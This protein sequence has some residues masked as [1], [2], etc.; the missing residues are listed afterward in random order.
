MTD[1]IKA[2][3]RRSA[4]DMALG[5]AMSD[6][7]KSYVAKMSGDMTTFAT[8]MS[9][10]LKAL[11]FD[12]TDGDGAVSMEEAE[13]QAGSEAEMKAID[14]AS[15]VEMVCDAVC[16][17]LDELNLLDDEEDDDA[18]SGMADAV[19]RIAGD[20][21]DGGYH[22]SDDDP[23]VLVYDE[24]AIA[25]VGAATWRVPY[26]IEAGDVV[27]GD[28][29]DWRRVEADWQEVDGAAPPMEAKAIGDA[30]KLLDDGTIIAQ[31]VRFGSPDEADLSDYR[32]YFTKSTDFWLGAWD[33]RP[34]LYHHAMDAGTRDAP[35]IGTWIK[36]WADD[37]GVWLQGQLDA[38]HKYHAAIKELAR[39]GLLRVST[40]SAPHLV[41]RQA[42][43]NGTHEVK[44][45]PLLAASLTPSPAEPRLLPAELKTILA[46][47][48]L[49]IDA[50]PEATQTENRERPDEAKA[51]QH[52]AR[53]L[54]LELDLLDLE[55]E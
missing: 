20:Y 42:A 45:W 31:A 54:A 2:G 27:I 16:D 13:T 25:M 4:A 19:R 7:M 10:Y 18:M 29:S 17:A 53:R 32:D 3:R 46:D 47:L 14:Y 1:A 33:R 11:G 5:R 55:N 44:T 35:I 6:E 50:G 22:E 8:K 43:Q 36:A 37:A 28:P 39:R 52:A 41:R 51:A 21:K 12:D 49:D 24:F 30:V 9:D 40:D 26:T 34:M 38:A 48:G 23:R 15:R